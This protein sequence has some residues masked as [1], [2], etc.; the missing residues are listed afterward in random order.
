MSEDNKKN[1]ILIIGGGRRGLALIEILSEFSNIYIMAVVDKNPNAS[2]IKLA[3]RLGIKTDSEWSKFLDEKDQP[4]AILNLTDNPAVLDD[5]REKV[6]DKGIEIMGDITS[7]LLSNMLMERQVQIELHRVSQKMTTEMGLDELMIL[8]LSS[9][10]KSTGAD[11]GIIIL[12]NESTWRWEIKSNWGIKE[13][14]LG[15]LLSEVSEHLPDWTEKD[16]NIILEYKDSD[17]PDTIKNN[18]C[19]PLLSRGN[20]IGAII[21]IRYDKGSDF[22][23]T[24]KRLLSTFA[25][26]SAVAIENTLLYKKTQK[27]SL[28]DG[29]T[30]LYNHRHF[31]EQMQV[32]LSRAQRYDLSF[33]LIMMDVDNFKDINDTYG[34]PVGDEI[35]IKVGK[36]LK[37]VLRESDMIARY[38]G[39][40]FVVLLPETPKE[41]ATIVGE[42]IRS[43]LIDNKIGGDIVVCASIGIS[44][45]PDDGVYSQDIISKADNALYKAKQDGRNRTYAA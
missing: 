38:G 3:Q 42:R 19:A 2:G 28:T 12:F 20:I 15:P 1:R 11:G 31:Q 8:M 26:Q 18:V 33:S 24:S 30:G 44:A 4:A 32:E 29:L 45:Y 6:R 35:L 14:L 39:D 7:D 41:G 17:V 27:L 9:C 22:S 43:G 34:H 25:N 36:H 40:E 13:E 23:V 21:I 10:V 37:K 5:I 16:D